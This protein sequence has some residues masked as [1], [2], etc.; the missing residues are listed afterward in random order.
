MFTIRGIPR[1]RR[2]VV[3]GITWDNGRLTGDSLL[4]QE[5]KDNARFLEGKKVGFPGGPINLTDHLKNPHAA[6]WILSELFRPGTIQ[7]SGELEPWPELPE[8][9]IA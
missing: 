3:A 8:G 7:V 2:K 4:V 9:A 6:A 5:A 1:H